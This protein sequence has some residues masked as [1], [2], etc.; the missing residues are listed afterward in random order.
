MGT[1]LSFFKKLVFF[2]KVKDHPT[3][4][5]VCVCVAVVKEQEQESKA[6]IG[7]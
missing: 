3:Q 4:L 7:F 1:P 5:F 6:E 2:I